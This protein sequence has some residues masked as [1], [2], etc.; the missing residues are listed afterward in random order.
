MANLYIDRDND[1]WFGDSDG[2][3]PIGQSASTYATDLNKLQVLAM[4]GTVS[5]FTPVPF[6]EAEEKFAL[7]LVAEDSGAASPQGHE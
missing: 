6:S 2:V 1:Y 3:M 5:H 4:I 7:R